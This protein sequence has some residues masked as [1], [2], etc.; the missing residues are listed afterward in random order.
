MSFLFGSAP[1][2]KTSTGPTINPIQEGILGALAT[3][4]QSGAPAPGSSPYGGTFAA[5]TNELQN[6]SLAALENQAMVASN[7]PPFDPTQAFNT[8][9]GVLSGKSGVS[10]TSVRPTGVDAPL[11]SGAPQVASNNIS[12]P[13]IDATQ[14]FR[15]GVVEP[16]TGD[17]LTRTLPS[18]AGKY[19]QTA[20]G[21]YGSE[22]FGAR[23][24]AA[25]DLER[26]LA[27]SGSTF[28]Y[29]AAAANQGVDLT[30]AQ[31]NASN[32]L[33]AALAN[34]TN[35]RTGQLANQASLLS[36]RTANQSAT[37]TADLANQQ[38]TRAAQTTN[39]SAILSALGLT[40]SVAS[41]G[42]T[43]QAGTIQNLL[44]TL[45]AGAVPYNVAQTQVSGEY[46]DYLNQLNVT[47]QRL[48]DAIASFSPSTIQTTSVAQGGSTGLLGGLIGG[49]GQFAGSAAGS[50][51]LASLLS[52][53]RA[54]ENYE[55]VGEVDGFPL[56]KFNYKHEPTNV[57]RIG[58]MAQDVE[59]RKPAAVT[60][61]NGLKHVDYRRA[62]EDVFA[63]AA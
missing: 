6:T 21:A 14:A 55:K 54:K 46:Q 63:E 40:P 24:N 35:D 45:G 32:A 30:A 53:K 49:A 56:Y 47:Q 18:I 48:A 5:P 58:L 29:N 61:I 20:G 23:S 22:A 33:T 31:T 51:A 17:F 2:V 38:D 60:T 34:Q 44:S 41:V 57:V 37:T 16:L 39:L 7:Q 27:Q 8:L 59:K 43:T 3:Y 13:H 42:N 62:L 9:A 28:A 10:S 15:Q 4:L 50:T 52:D 12:A 25:V 36:A 19:G 26:V 11:I 1:S